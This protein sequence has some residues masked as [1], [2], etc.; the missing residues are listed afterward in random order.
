M[1]LGPL[2]KERTLSC[3]VEQELGRL[4]LRIQTVSEGLL[5]NGRQEGKENNAGRHLILLVVEQL[6]GQVGLKFSE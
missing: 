2:I 5:N 3:K 6:N 1:T 4:A